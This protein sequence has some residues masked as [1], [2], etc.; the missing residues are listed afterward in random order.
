MTRGFHLIRKFKFK[1]G[2]DGGNEDP[3]DKAGTGDGNPNPDDDADKG[4]AGGNG[5]DKPSDKEAELLREVMKRK[6]NE[7]TLT[8][9]ISELEGSLKKFEGIDPEQVRQLLHEKTERERAELEK[10]GEFD[11]VKQQMV[12]QHQQELSKVRETFEAQVKELTSKVHTSESLI[13]DL[14]IGRSF[15]DSAFVRDT[16]TL[17]PS[18]ARV[19]YGSHF[20]LQDGKV[21]AYD[22]PGGDKRT[23]LVNAQ[24]EPLPF[25]Q[26]I[27]K[28][29][30][31][32]PDHE[33]LMRSKAKAGAGSKS[34]SEAKATEKVGSGRNRIAAAISGG[35][36]FLPKQ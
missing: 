34:D 11:R 25:D 32:D 6:G 7:R 35:A 8:N 31:A 21:V 15:G 1:E 22:K 20:E 16:L 19:V 28:I 29:V 26:A 23:L 10:R 13:T 36:L 2:E 9:K 27:E 14:T 3:A 5:G 30:K 33:H 12:E 18:K 17:T 24:G 4:G